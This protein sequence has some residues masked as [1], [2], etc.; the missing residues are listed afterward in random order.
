METINHFINGKVIAG[1]GDSHQAVFNPA[2]GQ[3]VSQVALATVGT[4][5]LAVSAA[6]A[7]FEDWS[8]QSPLRRARILS[9]FKSLMEQHRDEL[10]RLIV[11]EHGKVFDDALGEVARGIE[12]IEYACGA[13]TLLTSTFSDNVGGNIDNWNLRQPLGVCVGITPFNFP[14]MVP[15]WMIPMALATGNTFVLKPS[16]RDPSA[17]LMLAQLLQESGLPDGVFNVVQGG[18]NVV[19]HLLAHPEVEAVSFVGST[20]VAQYIHHTASANGKRV[21]ALGGAKNHMIIMPDADLD[22]AADALMG[23]AYGAA[24]ERCM[25]CSIAVAVGDIGDELVDKIQARIKGLRVGNGLGQNIDMGPLVTSEHRDRVSHYID[26]GEKEGANLVVDGRHHRVAGFE[27]GYFV[28]ATLFDKV[29]SEMAIYKDEIFG[30]VL[31]IVRA[32]NFSEALEL[33]NNHEFGNGAVCF[34]RDGAIARAFSRKVKAGMVGINVPIPVPMAWH[35]FGGWK[36]SLFGEHHAYGE[37]GIRFYTR[38]KSVMQRWPDSKAQGPEFAM[39]TA[40]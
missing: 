13:P 37:E 4:V 31:G 5:D 26:L 36:R 30:P 3:V 7:A 24:G 6:S 28:G 8:A 11:R 34:T 12:V 25:A 1:D 33:V 35:S 38:Y 23:A 20:P 19:D 10:A 9:R 39:P 14:V 15:L 32:E 16:E 21:Q 2:L 29:T 22:Q 27:E 40:H 17:S 18:K